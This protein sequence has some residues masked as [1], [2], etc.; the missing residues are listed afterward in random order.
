M[1][2][3]SP[4]PRFRSTV[5]FA[6]RTRSHA[7]AIERATFV[8]FSMAGRRFAAA[9]EAVV[10]VIRPAGES[11]AP[12]VHHAGRDVP[13]ADLAQALG[14]PSAPTSLTRVLI[15]TVPGGWI[16][17]AVDE[18]HEI[19]TVDASGITA[20][21][22]DDAAATIPGVRG[23]FMRKDVETFV[24]DVARALGFRHG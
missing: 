16:G 7:P 11:G 22:A 9:V 5:A 6:A 23:R 10:R 21:D 4:A 1:T 17:V 8:T 13:I 12:H 15:T 19:A 14:V 24:L 2:A 18:V 3:K 20:I